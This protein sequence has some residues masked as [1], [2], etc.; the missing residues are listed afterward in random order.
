[1]R[2]ESRSAYSQYVRR[3]Q[4]QQQQHPRVGASITEHAVRNTRWDVVNRNATIRVRCPYCTSLVFTHLDS[5]TWWPL[6]CSK[7]SSPGET[8][9]ELRHRAVA[10]RRK[11]TSEAADYR[12]GISENDIV[13][14]RII[15][16]RSSWP[17]PV[18][19]SW[20]TTP[21]PAAESTAAVWRVGSGRC[22][23]AAAR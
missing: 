1:M 3:A 8:R 12:S 21:P 11:K 2:R 10:D 22:A 18:R 20:P 9:P 16:A 4:Q 13:A 14:E 5:S 19:S 6:S 23:P 17:A 15:G 7:S